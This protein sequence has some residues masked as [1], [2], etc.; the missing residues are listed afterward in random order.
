M[1]NI[2]LVTNLTICGS[3]IRRNLLF[4]IQ[5]VVWIII[6]CYVYLKYLSILGTCFWKYLLCFMNFPLNGSF[7]SNTFL[8]CLKQSANSTC[9]DKVSN[10]VI[11]DVLHKLLQQCFYFSNFC[12]YRKY[13]FLKQIKG[14]L[15]LKCDNGKTFK[16]VIKC[17][18]FSQGNGLIS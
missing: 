13:D 3:I 15:I 2:L 6:P 10:C 4:L 11:S 9:C 18:N 1:P 14:L 7:K 5:K 12:I 8:T 16:I 17:F